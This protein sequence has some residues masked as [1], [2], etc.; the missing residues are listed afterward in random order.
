MEEKRQEPEDRPGVLKVVGRG[1]PEPARMEVGGGSAQEPR[2]PVFRRTKRLKI[3]GVDVD[4]P[5]VD[6]KSGEGEWQTIRL[7]NGDI[8]QVKVIISE[9][10]DTLQI[11]E[12]DPA[13]FFKHQLISRVVPLGGSRTPGVPPSLGEHISTDFSQ[14]PPED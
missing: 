7:E 9:V 5:S 2:P 11:V 12:G 14:G 10:Y 13:Y 8:I 1:K 4:C 6:F 3:N